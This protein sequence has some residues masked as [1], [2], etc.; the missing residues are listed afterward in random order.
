[1]KK[2][3]MFDIEVPA[4]AVVDVPERSQMR[5]GPMATAIGENAESLRLRQEAEAEIREENDRLAHE[6]VRLKRLGLVTDLVPIVDVR[7]SKLVRDRS[8]KRD[9]EIDE[10]KLSIREIGL[11]NPIRVE[12]VDDGYELVQGYRRLTAYRELYEETGDPV[13][14]TIPAGIIATGETL[15][16]LY[17][18]MV[19]ENLVRR[20]LSFWEMAS[21]ARAYSSDAAT[22]T[23]DVEA[24]VG[25]L[26]RAANRQKKIYIRHFATLVDLFE[27]SLRWPEAIPRALGLS[28]V[29]AIENDASVPKRIIA[30]LEQAEAGDPADEIAILRAF[31]MPEGSG[32]ALVS[33]R[34]QV[35]KV[36]GASAHVRKGKTTFRVPRPEG[37]ARCT[38][39]AGRVELRLDRDFSAIE[40]KRLERA[41]EAF[42]AELDSQ[43]PD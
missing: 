15:E 42:F 12:K 39:V 2:R 19:D 30:S 38:A 24:A 5:R 16:G 27:G 9:D 29:R 3:R 23:C 18:R 40:R 22:P 25:F 34:G 13:F 8:Q 1:M 43:R 4:E 31:T 10:L 6:F 28:L 36:E 20:D 41:V 35:G 7:M 21:L 32:A 14:A 37:D 11:S 17:R 26:F 33:P